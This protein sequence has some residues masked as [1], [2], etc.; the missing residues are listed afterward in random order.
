[1]KT[2]LLLLFS[3]I[4]F[5]Q[6][7]LYWQ[8]KN[9]SWYLSQYF[10]MDQ[11]EEYSTYNYDDTTSYF[12]SGGANVYYSHDYFN[13]VGKIG[14]RLS[15]GP[16]FARIDD[17]LFVGQDDKIYRIIMP[18]NIIQAVSNFEVKRLLQVKENL[19]FALTP[20]LKIYKSTDN[21][22]H[23]EYVTNFEED[24]VTWVS[25]GDE[26][27]YYTTGENELKK[28]DLQFSSQVLIPASDNI[29]FGRRM[30][31]PG[32]DTLFFLGKDDFWKTTDGGATFEKSVR[33]NLVRNTLY[34]DD[35]NIY[36]LNNKA[37]QKSSDLGTTWELPYSDATLIGHF[38]PFLF[39][40]N[41]I[42]SLYY[43][44][45]TI[46]QVVY[47]PEF[48]SP[49]YDDFF[50]LHVGNK[51]RFNDSV[52][53][54]SDLIE[55]TGEQIIDG[56]T[57]YTISNK[58]E[59]VRYENNIL[60]SHDGTQSKVE[61]DF[62]F[63]PGNKIN[64]GYFLEPEL[65]WEATKE[66]FDDTYYL[67]GPLNHELNVDEVEFYSPGFGPMYFGFAVPG[68]AGGNLISPKRV[69][70]ATVFQDGEFK[71]YSEVST[72]I[73]ESLQTVQSFELKNNYPNPFNPSTTI[74]YTIAK[75]SFVS[76]EIYNIQGEKVSTLVNEMQNAGEYNVG[77]NGSNL[78][79][80]VYFGR[81][82]ATTDGEKVFNRSI[83]MILMK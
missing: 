78:A 21:L 68:P 50:P 34:Y 41:G 51:W 52:I 61:I 39:A 66:F 13:H 62:R 80:G 81:F 53:M 46:Y 83:K 36:L 82:T 1:M 55:V 2:I 26:S 69:I 33:S 12:F 79:S 40:N 30:V 9:T 18:S 23:W 73:K 63:N 17:S 19:V 15:N 70:E 45:E 48:E 75:N 24:L 6:S 56:E 43:S 58:A 72:G 31:S 20:E 32:K 37:I 64:S 28:A 77:F 74:N 76:L 49:G 4:L 35:G 60:Y 16:N 47:N 71:Y 42:L 8:V 57:W 7:N 38:E 14:D 10:N 67:R 54:G 25:D 5:G 11:I 3:T 27:I 44:Q 22:R 59:P 29:E 65:M